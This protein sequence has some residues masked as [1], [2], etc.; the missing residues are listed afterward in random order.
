MTPC[1]HTDMCML[2][3]PCG[4]TDTRAPDVTNSN[5]VAA[6]RHKLS[7]RAGMIVLLSFI[8]RRNHLFAYL[9]NLHAGIQSGSK[10]AQSQRSHTPYARK[11]SSSPSNRTTLWY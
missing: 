6:E 5:R 7:K 4:A 10:P 3:P 1:G 9:F 11:S 8:L 2:M